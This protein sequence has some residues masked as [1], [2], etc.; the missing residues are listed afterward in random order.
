MFFGGGGGGFPPGFPFPGGFPHGMPGGHHHGGMGEEEEEIDNTSF[1]EILG[2]P[3]EATQGEIRKA[4]LRASTV[5]PRRHPDKGG[6]PALFAE[7]QG[8]YEVLSDAEKRARYDAG[9]EEAVK[10]GGGGGGGHSQADIFEAL[11]GGG[12]GGGG[13]G[14]ARGPP[15]M[16]PSTHPLRATLEEC[17]RGKTFKVAINRTVI[18]RDPNGNVMDRQKNRYQRSTEREVLDVTLERGAHEGQK[19]VFA[20]KGDVQDG[21]QQGDVILV[22]KVAEHPVFERKGTDLV[23]KR[24]ISLLEAISGVSLTFRSVSGAVVAVKSEPGM[25]RDARAPLPEAPFPLPLNA[26]P[27][28][29]PIPRPARAR[30]QVIKPDM[31]LEVPEEGMPVLGHTQVKGSLF[32]KFSVA[33]PE[34]LDLTDGMRKIL[35]GVFKGAP[36]AAGGAAALGEP[37]GPAKTLQPVDMEMRRQR[38]QLARDGEESDEDEGGGHPG[39]Q[40]AQ[41]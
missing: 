1:Y 35:A 10:G 33:F 9:G 6:E 3:R 40:C 24:D 26:A 29:S 21:M 39:V 5:G 23:M 7:L 27:P 30:A 31:L 28:T 37:D 11:F 36:A 15:K 20:N 17:W 16:E 8:A 18:R 4:Y 34:R 41:Q 13:G 32:I 12:R 22:V 19:I 2:L 25:V 14:G 38:E